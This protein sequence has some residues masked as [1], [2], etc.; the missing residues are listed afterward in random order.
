MEKFVGRI[1]KIYF[2]LEIHKDNVTNGK[3]VGE[4][5]RKGRKTFLFQKV[6]NFNLKI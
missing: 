2:S 3:N 5:E 1:K 6:T 4:R